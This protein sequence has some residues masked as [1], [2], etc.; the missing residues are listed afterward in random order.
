MPTGAISWPWPVARNRRSALPGAIY[1]RSWRPCDRAAIRCGF[2]PGSTTATAQ[3]PVGSVFELVDALLLEREAGHRPQLAAALVGLTADAL[4]SW[5]LALA[6]G[7]AADA[8]CYRATSA[9][10]KPSAVCDEQRMAGRPCWNGCGAT[11]M[12]GMA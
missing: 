6:H 2:E 12:S 10:A 4:A 1:P 5:P 3:T 7:F 9:V 8:A 11:A